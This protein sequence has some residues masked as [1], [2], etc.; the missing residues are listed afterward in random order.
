MRRLRILG[1]FLL[2]S[3]LCVL[4]GVIYIFA[5]PIAADDDGNI[6]KNA[7]FEMASGNLPTE[8]VLEDKVKP[9]GSVSLSKNNVHS[10]QFSLKL[11]PN[12]RNNPWDL[13]HDPLGLGQAFPAGQLR[14]KK[15]YVSGWLAADGAAAAAIVVVALGGSV[16]ELVELKQTSSKSGLV[17]REDVLM[18]PKDAKFLVAGCVAQG[19]SGAVYFDDIF[20]STAV[21]PS[22]TEHPP[23]EARETTPVLEAQVTIEAGSEIRKIP[24]TLYGMNTEWV[25]NGNGLWNAGLQSLDPE[26]VRLTKELGTTLLR[27]PGGLFA[28]FY[29]WR[30][31]IGQQSSRRKI[32]AM[33]GDDGS[34][35]MFGTDEALA[36]ADSSGSRLMIT[37]NAGSGTAKEAADWVRYVNRTSRRVEYWEVGNEL[38][39]KMGHRAFSDVTMTPEQ[40]GRKFVEFAREMRAADPGIK[41][42]AIGD[43]NYGTLSP[44]AYGDWTAKVLAIAGSDMDFLA[45]HNGYAPVLIRDKGQS[46]RRVYAAM[47]AA[48]ILVRETLATASRKIAAL[49]PE[50]DARIRL[51][52]TEWGPTFQNNP[53]DRFVDHVKTLGS[54]L[55]VAAAIKSFLESPKLDVATGFKLVDELFQGWIGKREGRWTPTA[56]YYALQLYTHHFGTILVPSRTQSPVYDSQ[57]AGL[58]DAL[59]NVPYLDVVSSR[60]EDGRELYIMAIN[61]HFDSPIQARISI[62]GREPAGSG[63]AWTLNGAGIDANT[64]THFFQAPGVKWAKQA[65]DEVNPR[66]DRGGPDEVT[67]TSKDLTGLAANFAYTFPAHSVSALEIRVR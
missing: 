17:F 7:S 23:K 50:R 51:A 33:P 35:P 36:L 29:H 40:Y 8:W 47:L 53:G 54:A 55:Y 61:K 32:S 22:W 67:V 38:Y 12:E 9:K 2:G 10:G 31:G 46:V 6:L 18:V 11:E 19:D 5:R 62:S 16:P 27:F 42:G 49:G 64:G 45:I 21:P 56:P 30:D 20:L 60:S 48:P 44:R 39:V 13:S 1:L 28:D 52:V 41:I 59:S 34:V 26:L 3:I 14:G 63:T 25:W 43:E 57:P 66:F 4:A 24:R 15:L 37:V 65:T 58:V